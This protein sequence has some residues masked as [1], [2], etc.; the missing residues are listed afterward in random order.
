VCVCV[1]VCVYVC[2]YILIVT[3]VCLRKLISELYFGAIAIILNMA[4]CTTEKRED[5]YENVFF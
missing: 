1:C 4:F 2:I 3:F 5:V